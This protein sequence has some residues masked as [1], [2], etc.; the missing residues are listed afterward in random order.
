MVYLLGTAGASAFLVV[1]KPDEA[2]LGLATVLLG[3]PVY[4]ALRRFRKTESIRSD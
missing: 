2:L 4:A 3:L 1:R